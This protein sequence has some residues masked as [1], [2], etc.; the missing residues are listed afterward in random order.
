MGARFFIFSSF[1]NMWMRFFSLDCFVLDSAAA[2]AN[3]HCSRCVLELED[4]F[5]TN[6]VLSSVRKNQF[7]NTYLSQIIRRQNG[8]FVVQSYTG[9]LPQQ[10]TPSTRNKGSL[11]VHCHCALKTLSQ[12]QGFEH[13][14]FSMR[15]VVCSI[16]VALVAIVMCMWHMQEIWLICLV[17]FFSLVCKRFFHI[18]LHVQSLF[19]SNLISFKI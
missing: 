17:H 1:S 7:L 11:L 9:H 2:V 10:L 14:S 16:A 15:F 19:P 12:S 5:Q 3:L 6:E 4:S 8:L 13:W 18:T